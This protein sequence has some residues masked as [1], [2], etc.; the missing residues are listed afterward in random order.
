MVLASKKEGT[1]TAAE[2]AQKGGTGRAAGAAFSN[3]LASFRNRV[4][5][6]ASSISSTMRADGSRAT[7]SP[8]SRQLTSQRTKAPAEAS[9]DSVDEGSA[10]ATRRYPHETSCS[11]SL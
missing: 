1:G 3:A 6:H 9:Q 11:M 4:D 8:Q 10:R 7:A 2:Q 5:T